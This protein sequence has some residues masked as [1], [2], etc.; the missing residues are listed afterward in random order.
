MAI[1]RSTVH[2][3]TA[4]ELHCSYLLRSTL[5]MSLNRIGGKGDRGI[6][7]RGWWSLPAASERP[8]AGPSRLDPGRLGSDQEGRG[9]R[10][11]RVLV[12][13][14]AEKKKAGPNLV[15]EME[16]VARRGFDLLRERSRS[17]SSSSSLEQ[18]ED[19]AEEFPSEWI[20][21]SA[22]LSTNIIP[23]IA[24]IMCTHSGFSSN[25]TLEA[26]RSKVPMLLLHVPFSPEDIPKYLD[27]HTEG[28]PPR[29]ID[30]VQADELDSAHLQAVF[31]NA[32]LAGSSGIL[33]NDLELRK[34]FRSGVGTEEGEKIGM[35][36]YWR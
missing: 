7:L 35:G 10:R 24:T 3:G 26:N 1:K 18:S 30:Q 23:S 11:V 34:E 14:K 17:S 8:I 32:A 16:G 9:Q 28:E 25:A 13:C 15:R 4:F 29:I 6:D 20:E 2:L 36:L 12:Q 27:F 5:G 19:E 22:N 21:P 31:W 33:G